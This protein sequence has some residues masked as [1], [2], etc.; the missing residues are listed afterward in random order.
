MMKKLFFAFILFPFLSLSFMSCGNENDDPDTAYS[1]AGVWV[2]V[3]CEYEGGS[4]DFVGGEV[5]VLNSDGTGYHTDIDD[6]RS[7]DY[8]TGD[9][10]VRYSFSHENSVISIWYTDPEEFYGDIPVIYLD[11]DSMKWN[12]DADGRIE[13]WTFRRYESL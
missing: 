3:L 11:A 10:A 2:S 9:S 1:I 12:L 7:G 6:Y 13:T 4:D 5:W 8:A